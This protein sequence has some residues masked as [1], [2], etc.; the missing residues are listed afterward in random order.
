M[1]SMSFV[2][3]AL[4]AGGTFV[5]VTLFAGPATSSQYAKQ[6]QNTPV[7]ELPAKAAELI[8]Q[9]PEKERATVTAEVIAVISKSKPAAIPAVVGTIARVMPQQAAVA[10]AAA[11][12]YQPELAPAI[13][14]ATVT[15]APNYLSTIVTEACRAAP[16]YFQ[17]IALGAAVAAP[18]STS[19]I[20]PASCQLSPR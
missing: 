9:A 14:Q 17:G 11:S 13:V 7:L 8:K 6:L 16:Q 5:F 4:I 3:G 12:E 2:L 19:K 15:S 10:A 18:G 1:K 20:I